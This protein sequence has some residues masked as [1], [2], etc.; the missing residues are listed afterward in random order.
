MS[1]APFRLKKQFLTALPHC[2]SSAIK[3][4]NS[5][6]G[7]QD[8]VPHSLP[9]VLRFRKARAKMATEGEKIMSLESKSTEWDMPACVFRIL[10]AAYMRPITY[11]ALMRAIE[12]KLAGGAS[13]RDCGTWLWFCFQHFPPPLQVYRPPSKYTPPPPN[14]VQ[15]SQILSDT[16]QQQN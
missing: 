4:W 6:T 5:C 11:S 8:L 10:Y 13:S 16:T 3:T 9:F 12:R 1:P 7:N 2:F 15:D 14:G